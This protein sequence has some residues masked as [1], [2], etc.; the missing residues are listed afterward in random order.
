MAPCGQIV[1]TA[2]EWPIKSKRRGHMQDTTPL[3]QSILEKLDCLQ[4]EIA[5]LR[6]RPRRRPAEG[7]I[8]LSEAAN[9]CGK[10]QKGLVRFLERAA[11]DPDEIQV[12]RIRGG[13]HRAD[14]E[15]LLE[16]RRLVGRGERVRKAL[17]A[18]Q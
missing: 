5:A 15:R 13:V 10:T 6:G 11:E 16:S 9:F 18:I 8:S 7:Y 12:R 1:F 4:S 17:E 3:L 2:Q 14:L